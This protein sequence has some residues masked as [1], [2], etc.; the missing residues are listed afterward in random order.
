MWR[1]RSFF[2]HV[3]SNGWVATGF[4]AVASGVLVVSSVASMLFIC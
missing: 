4:S 3:S 2:A 1:I